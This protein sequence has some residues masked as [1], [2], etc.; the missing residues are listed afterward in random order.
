MSKFKSMGT[1]IY[2]TFKGA[3]QKGRENNVIYQSLLVGTMS[4]T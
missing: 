1:E 3:R 4:T 2:S